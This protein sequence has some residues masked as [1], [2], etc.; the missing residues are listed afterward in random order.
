M[1]NSDS[2]RLAVMSGTGADAIEGLQVISRPELTTPFGPPSPGL[3]LVEWQG[4]PLVHLPRHG[5]DHSLAPHRINYRAN[6]YALQQLGVGRV[7]AL[8]AVGGIHADLL[9]PGALAVPDQVVDYTWGREMSFFDG[10]SGPLEHCDFTWP[11]AQPLREILITAA[12]ELGVVALDGGV[13]GVT[14][15][16]RL[17]T[18][19]EINRL[20]RD[21]CDLVGMT[22]MP[23]AIL[24]RELGIEY[25]MLTVTVNAA[26]GRGNVPILEEFE[27]QTEAAIAGAVAVL[28]R[29]VMLAVECG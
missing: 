28:E 12:A 29:A 27:T 16:P 2:R 1:A 9:A 14:Q 24:A 4:R 6:L 3:A 11:F 8:G 22:A 20:Q 5:S 15:G 10:E 21:G 23:E 25:A 18:V 19:A 13:Y 7:F 17:E 26:A